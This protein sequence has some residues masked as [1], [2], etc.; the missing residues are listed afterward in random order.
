MFEIIR[1]MAQF[2]TSGLPNTPADSNTLQIIINT[3][4]AIAGAIA[5]LTVVIAG[6][7]FV[8]SRGNPSETAK[9][10]NAIIFAVIG[11][12]ILILAFPIVNF[13]IFR[14]S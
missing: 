11:L 12:A 10:R 9:A 14:V 6:F 4:M 7:R 13:I 2:D 1:F 8:T 5:V 3:V